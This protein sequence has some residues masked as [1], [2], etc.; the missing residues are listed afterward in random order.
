MIYKLMWSK[1]VL[2]LQQPEQYI[3]TVPRRSSGR[4]PSPQWVSKVAALSF[5][6]E[7]IFQLLLKNL[8]SNLPHES[9]CIFQHLQILISKV[10]ALLKVAALS[11]EA[12]L[13]ESRLISKKN[14]FWGLTKQILH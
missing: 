1:V 8:N 13:F 14:V 11:K 6:S 7:R 3:Q 10:I 2:T 12:D 5:E 4:M 9:S